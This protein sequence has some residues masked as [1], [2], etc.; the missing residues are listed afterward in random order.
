M[1]VVLLFFEM[2]SRAAFFCITGCMLDENEVPIG[3]KRVGKDTVADMITYLCRET[4]TIHRLSF[5]DSLKDIICETY[6]LNR[7][8][9]EQPENKEKQIASLPE[10][11]TYR[12]L[13]E[14]YGSDVVR[15]LDV[16]LCDS[17]WMIKVIHKI[18]DIR[19]D[20]FERMVK[21][22]FD[23]TSQEMNYSGKIPR[24]NCTYQTLYDKLWATMTAKKM[25]GF[26]MTPT[27][28]ELILITD[29]RFYD[30]F[31]TMENWGANFIQVQRHGVNEGNKVNQHPSNIVDP[32][33]FPDIILKND[34]TLDEL[35]ELVAKAIEPFIKINIEE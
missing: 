17:T 28:P 22:T 9:M 13:L 27:K 11:W 10:G 2:S 7:Q 8:E 5:A 24:F 30:E 26:Q 19:L 33:M 25:P 20:S 34:G 18:E 21:R 32:R 3:Q 23:L 6:Q 29:A 31:R 1:P 14:V 16:P 15:H 4:H 12:K 35:R